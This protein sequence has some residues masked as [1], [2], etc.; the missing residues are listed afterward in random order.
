MKKLFLVSVVTMCALAFASC[1]KTKE[2]VCT[3]T[4]NMPEMGPM[5][6]TSEVTIND[7]NCEDM[8]VTQ[9]VDAYG[10]TITQTVDCI[11]K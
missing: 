7:G 5:T 9:N 10:E 6:A 8:N 3:T 2:C 4:Q 11:E 1:D